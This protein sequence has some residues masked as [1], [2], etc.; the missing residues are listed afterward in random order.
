MENQ[1]GVYNV[2]QLPFAGKL[3]ITDMDGTLLDSSAK[4]SKENKDA[5]NRFIEG[6]GLFTVATGRMEKSVKRFFPE[7]PL[8]VPAIL[9]NGAAIYDFKKEKVLWQT[10]LP[11]DAIDPI[12]RVIEKFPGMGV[13]IYHGGNIYFARQN[14]YTTAHMEREKLRPIIAEPAEIPRPWRKVLFAWDP[15]KLKVVEESLTGCG[16]LFRYT[17]SEPFFLEILNRNTSKGN[18]LKVLTEMLGISKSSVIAMGDNLNDIEMIEQASIGI[19]V[20][21]AHEALKV[22]A[23]ICCGHHDQ[24]A[25][26]QVI[27]W[28]ENG[29][30][31]C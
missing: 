24:N 13:Q 17:Y 19:A 10:T 21:N 3:L 23:D 11:L 6:G 2:S 8:N 29:R 30:L 27:R 20:E 16:N 12:I 7:L 28:L 18:A 9:Y 1:R 22:A 4:I 25:V 14:E 26:S 31:V 5:I 15:E